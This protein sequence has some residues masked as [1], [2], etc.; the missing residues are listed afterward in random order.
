MKVTMDVLKS[1]AS[2]L[3]HLAGRDK[4]FGKLTR[5]GKKIFVSIGE[6]NQL[7]YVSKV[8]DRAPPWTLD[9]R[10]GVA[11]RL[12][13]AQSRLTGAGLKFTDAE[14]RQSRFVAAGLGLL[15]SYGGRL[16]G[17]LELTKVSRLNSTLHLNMTKINFV[18]L[19]QIIN[20]RPTYLQK[21]LVRTV[22]ANQTHV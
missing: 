19:L 15:A 8:L 17:N 4:L 5:P 11:S 22:A 10:V 12:V 6:P 9:S 16:T 7:S 2:R 18:T 13:G 20:V 1:L 21:N 14:S 3:H